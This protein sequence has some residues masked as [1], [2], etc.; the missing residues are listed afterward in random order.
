MLNSNK[1]A[2]RIPLPYFTSFHN[3]SYFT[4]YIVILTKSP[5]IN[6]TT[7]ACTRYDFL[8]EKKM[9]RIGVFLQL[10]KIKE[11]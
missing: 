7:V 5:P 4:V 11:K 9:S 8:E 3:F 10:R 2:V 6:S 1:K